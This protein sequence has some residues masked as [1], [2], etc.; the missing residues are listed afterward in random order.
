MLNRLIKNVQIFIQQLYLS[1]NYFSMVES[2]DDKKHDEMLENEIMEK[3]GKIGI[4]INNCYGGFG[5]SIQGFNALKSKGFRFTK[6]KRSNSIKRTC[7]KLIELLEDGVENINGDYANLKVE[8]IEKKYTNGSG[9]W[10]IDEYDGK[11]YIVIDENGYE[12]WSNLR[13]LYQIHNEIKKIIESNLSDCIKYTKI[14]TIYQDNQSTM[15]TTNSLLKD[16]Y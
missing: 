14:Q 15:D 13:S 4:V 6:P 7:K 5:V 1:N 9:F 3:D 16:D 11:E 12:M 10:T 8:Y 2:E